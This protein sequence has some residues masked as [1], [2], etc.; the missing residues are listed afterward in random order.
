M[1]KHTQGEWRLSG[2]DHFGDFMLQPPDEEYAI[3]AIT[4]GD[5]RRMGG[6]WDEHVANAHLLHAAPKLY[7]ALVMVREADNDVRTMPAEA[8]ARI[9]RAIAAAEGC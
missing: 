3:A 8:R 4:N 6:R 1:A 9:D 5:I 2:P 7:E